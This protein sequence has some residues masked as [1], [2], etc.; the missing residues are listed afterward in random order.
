MKVASKDA[1]GQF[2][3]FIEASAP[4]QLRL[5]VSSPCGT[6]ATLTIHGSQYTIDFGPSERNRGGAD[7]WAG[8]LPLRWAT[9]LFLGKIPCPNAAIVSAD[10]RVITSEDELRIEVPA[11]GEAAPAETFVCRFRKSDPERPGRL[12]RESGKTVVDF[13]FGD[14]GPPTGS[15]SPDV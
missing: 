7:I 14:L 12:H 4:D 15:R 8:I 3:A 9:D 11:G 5:E 2:S 10:A 13:V 6:Y 1:S